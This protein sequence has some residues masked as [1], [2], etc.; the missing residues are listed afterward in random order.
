[1]TSGTIVFF[2]FVHELQKGFKLFFIYLIN[3]RLHCVD[4]VVSDTQMGF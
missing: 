4:F 1:M 3:C 2:F